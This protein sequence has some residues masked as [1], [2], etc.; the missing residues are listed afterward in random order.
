MYH[1]LQIH[2]AFLT[3]ANKSSSL[4]KSSPTGLIQEPCSSRNPQPGGSMG[5]LAA[6]QDLQQQQQLGSQGQPAQPAGSQQHQQSCS[7]G[8]VQFC[9][10]CKL[11]SRSLQSKLTS[12]AGMERAHLRHLCPTRCWI[13]TTSQWMQ[14]HV[15]RCYLPSVFQWHTEVSSPSLVRHFPD[16]SFHRALALK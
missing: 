4:A 12:R 13:T 16:K 5:V 15:L 7:E 2:M 11:K 14:V 9:S 8:K 3:E 10:L 1:S 6:T